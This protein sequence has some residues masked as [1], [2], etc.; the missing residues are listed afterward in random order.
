MEE[1][2]VIEDIPKVVEDISYLQQVIGEN[3]FYI[4]LDSRPD[5]KEHVE[6]ELK[7]LGLKGTRFSA[8]KN[9]KGYIGCSMSHIQCIEIAKKRKLDHVLIV[10]D[11]I[12][13][14]NPDLLIN[15]LIKFLKSNNDFD[16]VL[17]A[18]NNDSPY[19]E[20][21]NCCIRVYNCQ[22]ATGYLVKSHYYDYLIQNYKEGLDNLI[23]TGLY[24]FYALDQYWKKLQ[25]INKWYLIIPLSVVQKDDYSDIEKR[26]VSYSS[27]MMLLNKIKTIERTTTFFYGKK[28]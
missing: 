10:E 4:N 13:F 15:Q 3:V 16:V 27:S 6:K 14:T 17:L 1:S 8:I 23:K 21:D 11:D 12:T 9:Q 2:K 18:G 24:S 20:I 22:T 25:K 19:K 26:D 7:K 5:R 28:R